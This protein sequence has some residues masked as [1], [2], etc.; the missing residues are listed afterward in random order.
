M[1]FRSLPVNRITRIFA[2]LVVMGFGGFILAEET[3]PAMGIGGALII[4]G[5]SVII[6]QSVMIWRER[7]DP[8]D[9]SRLWETEPQPEEPEEDGQEHYLSYCHHCGGSMSEVYSICPHCG[10]PLGA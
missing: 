6:S 10:T 9:L 5:L 7:P 1:L 4:C 8:Y 3:F 2:G